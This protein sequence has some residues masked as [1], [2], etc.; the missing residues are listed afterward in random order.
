MKIT[1]EHYQYMKETLST[2]DKST[3]L[4][5]KDSLLEYK[6]LRVIGA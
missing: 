1:N 2:L 4:K 5:H 6:P 3:V